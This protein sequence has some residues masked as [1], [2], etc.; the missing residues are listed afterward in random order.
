MLRSLR[1]RLIL[2]M[3]ALVATGLLAADV[4]TYAYVR[5][6]LLARVDTQLRASATQAGTRELFGR[7]D[8]PFARGGRGLG[9]ASG[10]T[11]ASLLDRNGHIIAE[12]SFGFVADEAR[13]VLPANVIAADAGAG[14]RF[15]TSNALG[16]SARYRLLAVPLAGGGAIVLAIPLGDVRATLARLL[17]VEAI[18]TLAV[19]AGIIVLASWLVRIGLQPLARMEAV[20]TEIAAGD[21]TKRV[22]PADPETEVGRLGGALNVMLERIESAFAQKEASE[23][24]LRRFVADASHELRTPLTSIRGYA[25]LFRHGADARPDDLATSMRRIEEESARMGG[26]VDELLLLARLDQGRPLDRE[27][28]DLA[29]VVQDAVADARAA[30]PGRE[31]SLTSDDRALVEG[32]PARLHQVVANLLSNALVHTPASASVTALVRVADGMVTL[33]IADDGPGMP[34]EHAER[35]FDRFFRADPA[36]A[37]EAGGTGLGLSIARSIVEAH[38]G[39]IN[40][41]SAPGA[42]TRITVLLPLPR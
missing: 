13:P 41:A 30:H 17:A 19:I 3:V 37:R 23:A 35:A 34:P 27:I 16:S 8:R 39:R 29:A 15:F 14:L 26:L 22:E 9:A 25:E 32:D 1:G 12:R 38:G 4:A 21:L 11:Y 18:A 31:V 5:S 2:A 6:S 24:R 36:R 40:L 28:V 20:A 33:E 42:G 7:L 10:V